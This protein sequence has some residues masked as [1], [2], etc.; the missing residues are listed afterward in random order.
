MI[1][2]IAMN[3]ITADLLI[4]MVNGD[5]VVKNG[6]IAMDGANITCVGT[7]DELKKKYP[8]VQVQH[9]KNS[10]LMPGLVCAFSRP[11]L[12]AFRCIGG[13]PS[14]SISL[15]AAAIDQQK[16]LDESKSKETI[17]SEFARWVESGITTL[18]A[19]TQ[20]AA[21]FKI[22]KDA[23]I[24]A[25]VMPEITGGASDEAQDTFE[26]ALALVDENSGN[27]RVRAGLAPASA[28]LLSRPLLKLTAEHAK[29]AKLPLHIR[30]SASFA[31]MEFFFDSQGPIANLLFPRLGWKQI[32]PPHRQTPIQYLAEI[33]F[34]NAKTSI[35]GGAQLAGRDFPLLA[36]YSTK[37]IWCPRLQKTLNSGRFPWRKLSESGIPVAIGCEDW[38]LPEGNL[39]QEMRI[40]LTDDMVDG[41][42]TA[43]DLLY[44]ATIGGARSLRLE[45]EIGSFE[46]GKKADYIIVNKPDGEDV[47]EAL[48]ANTDAMA[49]VSAVVD[50]EVVK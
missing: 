15:D 39:W 45:N 41:D 31:E 25:V 33:G 18:G 24:R 29:Q 5:P 10:V 36:K 20:S 1:H 22:A 2:K 8:E 43:K 32:P 30:A 17:K 14:D 42:V 44:A 47:Y 35:V 27:G 46:E 11:E 48:I 28:Y 26:T 23:G 3:I 21:T 13:I 37:V 40:A 16:Q 19:V 50:G 12:G 9:F 38:A 49:I 7:A 4:T 6:G 34:L